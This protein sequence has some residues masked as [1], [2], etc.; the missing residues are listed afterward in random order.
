MLTVS[1]SESP[2]RLRTITFHDGFFTAF[3]SEQCFYRTSGQLN[4]VLSRGKEATKHIQMATINGRGL[5]SQ[6]IRK[7][8]LLS[9]SLTSAAAVVENGRAIAAVKPLRHP[10]ATTR[11]SFSANCS[12]AID[13]AALTAGLK[14]RLFKTESN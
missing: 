1:E 8:D 7:S 3:R 5:G 11:S 4:Q 12:A 13:F 2:I 6:E 10:K 14:P 9:G